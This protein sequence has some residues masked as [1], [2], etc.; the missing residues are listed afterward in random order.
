MI[1]SVSIKNFMQIPDLELEFTAPLTFIAGANEAGKS[2]IRDAVLWGFT[3]QARGLKTHA[4]QAAFIREGAKAA[5][6]SIYLI[7]GHAF[8]RRK[9]AKTAAAILGDIPDTGLNPALLFDPHTFLLYTEDQ[10][11]ELLFKVIPGLN[12]T[13]DGVYGRLCRWPAIETLDIQNAVE[14]HGPDSQELGLTAKIILNTA[15]MAASHGFPASEKEA[16]IKRREAK[17]V[18]E[19][20]KEVEEPEKTITID[21]KEYDI[22]TLNLQAIEAT[23]KDLQKEKDDLLR[24]KGAEEARAKRIAKVQ[25]QLEQTTVPDAPH[26]DEIPILQGRLQAMEGALEVNA[27]EIAQAAV[28]NQTFPAICSAINLEQITCPKAGQTVG[29]EP[30][31]PGVLEA[32]TQNRQGLIKKRDEI[33]TALLVAHQ[34]V[35]SCRTAAEKKKNLEE[36]LARLQTEPEGGADLDAEITKRQQRIARGD[37]FKLAAYQYDLALGRY[38]DNQ[39]KLAAAE[40]EVL[41]YDALAKALAP[42]GIPSQMI[43]EALDGINSLLEEAA[44]FLFA[45]RYL[46]LTGDLGIVLQDSPYQT[47]SKSAKYRV[48]VAFQYAL[49]RL[50]GAR[51]LLIDEADILDR[52]HQEAL[53]DFL[54]K[55][56]PEFEQILVF[57]TTDRGPLTKEEKAAGKKESTWPFT[58]YHN[59]L[60]A[61]WLENGQIRGRN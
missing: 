27:Q 24:Q 52:S 1:K 6:V 2:S 48:G 19:A 14:G 31:A 28:K 8:T 11:R 21:G 5:E 44:A 32:L 10:R 35:E 51:I 61:L 47:L 56:L 41:I 58:D 34:R 7:D 4:D 23:L 15:K 60:Q 20:Y 53:S 30:A 16:V 55:H 12:P 9:T 40:L 49:A 18:R 36:E 54:V 3:G 46:H 17:R 39:T 29:A 45:G 38:K 13:A 22:P 43:A 37:A 42:D 26:P 59:Q 50:T 57:V 33:N 25:S